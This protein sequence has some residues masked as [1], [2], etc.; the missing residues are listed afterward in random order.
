MNLRFVLSLLIG[1]FIVVSFAS[2]P[3]NPLQNDDAA[4]YALAAKNAIL[5]NQWLAQF[6]TPGDLSSFLDKPPLGIWLLAW[7]PKIAGINALTIHIPNVLYY[8]LLLLLVYFSLSRLEGKSSAFYTTL[9][10]GTSLA[11]VVYS[12][13]PKLDVLLPLFIA[14]AHFSIYAFLKEEKPLYLYLFSLSLA[15]GFLVKSGF[16]LIFPALTVAALV[17]FSAEAREKL[18]KALFS[19]HSFLCFLLLSAIV[20]IVL[21]L[22]SLA[23]KEQW[24]PYLKSITIQSKYNTSYLGLGFYYSIVGFLLI[25]IFPWAP[26]WLSSF[27]SKLPSLPI[28]RSH[29]S[30]PLFCNFWFWSNFLFLLFFYR[31][32]DFRT[33][34]VFVVPLAIVAGERLSVLIEE[35]TAVK[36]GEILWNIF[37]F[38]IFTIG[39]LVI[40]RRP[41]NAEGINIGAALPPVGLF[42]AALGFLTFFYLKPSAKAFA[43]AFAL[44]ILSYSVLF[45]NTRPLADA[46]NPDHAWSA[47]I[48]TLRQR[49]PS[50][51]FYI[52]RPPDRPLFFSPDLFWVDFMAG[53]A[54]R[55]FWDRNELIKSLVST[56]AIVLSDTQSYTKLGVRPF[57]VLAQDQYSIL[58]I[59]YGHA[60]P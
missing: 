31:Q 21:G 1:I 15:C 58:T 37:Y 25:A 49:D 52:Y 6:V 9:I 2:L 35:K 14:A 4:L 33:F 46:F 36:P 18:F 11:L 50:V 47:I 10:A 27:R 48:R 38:L 44:I 23:L 3:R 40:F 20:G 53:P 59:N 12:R 34:T 55:Y 16:G 51:Q 13:A 41:V 57:A 24:L 30:L 29:L 19:R 60:R 39:F 42:A 43:A 7:I 32:T 5:Y 28:L 22:Q 17:L 56:K 26:L 54:D 45:Y 8:C